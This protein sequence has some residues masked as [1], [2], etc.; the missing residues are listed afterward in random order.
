MQ[1]SLNPAEC[2]MSK[3]CTFCGQK[4]KALEYARE[5]LNSDEGAGFV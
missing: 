5:L 2:S 3:I 4:Q 1:G